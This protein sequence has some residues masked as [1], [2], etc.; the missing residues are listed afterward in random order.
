MLE[1][2]ITSVSYDHMENKKNL[3]QI[4]DNHPADHLSSAKV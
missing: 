3:S 4:Y 2:I 1:S